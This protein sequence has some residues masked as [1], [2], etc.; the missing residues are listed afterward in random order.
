MAKVTMSTKVNAPA[1]RL[2][3]VVGGFNALPDW[4][5]AVEKSELE[6]DGKGSLRRLKIAG[7]GEVVERLESLNE[8]ERV[9]AYSIVNGPL[10]VA[11]YVSELSVKDN[12]DGTSTLQWS[13]TFLP[14]GVSET[15]A[16]KVIEGIYQA[17]FDNLRKMFRC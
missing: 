3:Q 11:N 15:E 17:G 8:T 6:G 4:H 5:P 9:Y 10:P 14:A 1:A 13:S 12:L 2:W 7:G 16:V